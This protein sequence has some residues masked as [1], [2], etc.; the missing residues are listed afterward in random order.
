M[1]LLF[2][3]YSSSSTVGRSLVLNAAL[4][5]VRKMFKLK[6]D[7][8]LKSYNVQETYKN[9]HVCMMK[10]K[11]VRLKIIRNFSFNQ[12][13]ELFVLYTTFHDINTSAP[14]WFRGFSEKKNA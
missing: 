9:C 2:S 12:R 4:R 8:L 13:L 5:F 6:H 10:Y 7:T 3:L 14:G 11:M 1:L